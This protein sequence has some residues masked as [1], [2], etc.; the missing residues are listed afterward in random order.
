MQDFRNSAISQP[1]TN[2]IEYPCHIG[3]VAQKD[4]KIKF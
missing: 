1:A 3:S 2:V 4:E